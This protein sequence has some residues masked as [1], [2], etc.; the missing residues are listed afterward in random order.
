MNTKRR[1]EY[2][3]VRCNKSTALAVVLSVVAFV[4]VGVAIWLIIDNGKDSG[5]ASGITE[6]PSSGSV[7]SPTAAPTPSPT[8]EPTPS[9][10]PE[11]YQ[12]VLVETASYT[13]GSLVLVNWQTGYIHTSTVE[14]IPVL[15]YANE[16]LLVEHSDRAL[17]EDVLTEL[18]ALSDA[19]YAVTGGDMLYVTGAFRTE[20]YQS[21]LYT[22]YAEA[23]GEEMA[24]IYV[25]QPGHSEHHTG[26]AVDLST[27][28]AEGERVTV[29]EHEFNA[30]L[31]QNAPQYGFVLRYP[32]GTEEITHVAYEPWHFRYIGRANALAVTALDMVYEE[33][34]EHLTQYSFEG[35][36]LWVSEDGQ[37][38]TAQFESLPTSGYLI[39]YT[40]ASDG[41]VTS[42][43]IPNGCENYSISGNNVDGF[44][45][46][47]QL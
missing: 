31:M 30:W 24:S 10:T 39:Y 14:T 15:S 27:M 1:N 33:Y 11:P 37:I 5:V 38:D 8:P 4:L 22:D 18:C 45:I 7:V 26:L 3:Q 32:V 25:A 40:P 13:N 16:H 19:F 29:Y 2:P 42:I 44:I 47:I 20:A 23:H 17:R 43:L 35:D 36:M 9:P 21:T 28:S 46:T 12:T 34:I 6:N 41:N